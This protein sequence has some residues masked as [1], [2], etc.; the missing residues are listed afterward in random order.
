MTDASANNT[1]QSTP[2]NDDTQPIVATAVP[3]ATRLSFLPR[4]FGKRMMEVETYIFNRFTTLCKSY[5]GGYW[6]FYDLSNGG[7]YLALRS[8]TPLDL[9]IHSNGFQGTVSPDAAGIIVTLF[10]LSELAFRHENEEIFSTRFHQL[11]D[12]AQSHADQAL[13]FQAID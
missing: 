4:H 1:Q 5:R 9:D 7:C 13:I 10:T 12:F 6:E 8:Q 3:V 2:S 11:R